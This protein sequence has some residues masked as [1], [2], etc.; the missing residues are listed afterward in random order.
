MVTGKVIPFAI[1]FNH[2]TIFIFPSSAIIR[3]TTAPVHEVYFA[4]KQI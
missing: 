2:A 4:P 1:W 3:I